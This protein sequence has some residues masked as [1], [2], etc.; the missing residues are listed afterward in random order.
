MDQ[1]KELKP[2]RKFDFSIVRSLRMKQGL[3]AEA[4]AQK[5]NI[6]RATVVKLESGKGNPTIETLGALGR[7]FG[8]DASQL[9]QMTETGTTEPGETLPYDQ[10]GFQGTQVRFPGFEIFVL[11]AAKG[12]KT[13]ATPDLHDNTAEICLVLSGRMRL[14][15]L[16]DSRELGPGQALRFKA[17]QPHELEA[18]EDT[19]LLLIHHPWS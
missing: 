4:L 2:D 14:T 13:L 18:L 16:E 10:E 7:V 1:T 8:L 11:T 17:L 12:A 5:A 6:T 9:V 19:E 3:T 15:I